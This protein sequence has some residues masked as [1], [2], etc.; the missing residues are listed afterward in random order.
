MG[1]TDIFI[2]YAR[3]DAAWVRLL[4]AELEL[5]GLSVFWDLRIPAGQTWRSH[6]GK[7]L[8]E[9]R[10]VVVVWSSHSIE[11]EWVIEETDQGKRRRV[12]VPVYKE[13][14]N[15][16]IGFG[17]VQAA[18][19]SGWRRG[20]PSEEFDAFLEDLARVLGPA[21]PRKAEP[22]PTHPNAAAAIAREQSVS[23][24]SVGDSPT[25]PAAD[26]EVSE[27]AAPD[28][29][30]PAATNK[31]KPGSATTPEQPLPFI[32]LSRDI[33]SN[34]TVPAPE[35]PSVRRPF[36]SA[37]PGGRCVCT[38]TG[39]PGPPTATKAQYWPACVSGTLSHWRDRGWPLRLN[40][41]I[42][43]TATG[44]FRGQ[45]C[46][47]TTDIGAS[48]RAGDTSGR[49]QVRAA[50]CRPQNGAM[51]AWPDFHRHAEGRQPVP[52]LPGDGGSAGW[53]FY[54]GFVRS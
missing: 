2:S 50:A 1:R 16:P 28:L 7:A 39:R 31:P 34:S 46:H 49:H 51:A 11:S 33:P 26:G 30:A 35:R 52:V 19:L 43:R 24:G 8:K 21:P 29:S 4:A 10:C 54:D 42:T 38:A 15:P 3:E 41:A 13:L 5:H 25:T 6:I 18:D 44:S 12:L 45:A 47:G 48:C 53:V 36:V 27:A 9:A 40:P 23:I 22:P 37:R 14:V 17:Q 20:Q 32:Q